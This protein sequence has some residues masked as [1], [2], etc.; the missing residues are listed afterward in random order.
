MKNVMMETKSMMINAQTYVFLMTE[1]NVTNMALVSS[2]EN[3]KF[4][5]M[6]CPAMI[7]ITR[8]EMVAVQL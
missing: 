7:T 4:P 2:E 5:F 6:D 8:V 1:Y 3:Y